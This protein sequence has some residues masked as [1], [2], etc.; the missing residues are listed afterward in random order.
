MLLSKLP[1]VQS[2]SRGGGNLRRNYYDRNLPKEK[3]CS[4]QWDTFKEVHTY[5]QG[6]QGNFVT[7][8]VEM[9]LLSDAMECS[10]ADMVLRAPANAEGQDHGEGHLQIN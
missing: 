10:G 6:G 8:M 4:I 9:D 5:N 2:P 3:A 1:F 7:Q